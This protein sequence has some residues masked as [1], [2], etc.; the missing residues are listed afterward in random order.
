VDQEMFNKG[1]R[2]RREMFGE[3]LAEKLLAAAD[4]FNR[5]FED[6]VTQYCF[7]EVWG[8]P[9]LD[10]KMRSIITLAMVLALNRPNQVAL[11]VRS[12]IK[13]GASKDEIRELFMQAAIYCGV[14][15]AVESFRIAREVFQELGI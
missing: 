5:P 3:G 15:A 9:G 11:H 6:M 1:L 4:D 10:R 8:R 12:S 7:G 2:I 13:H 14:P